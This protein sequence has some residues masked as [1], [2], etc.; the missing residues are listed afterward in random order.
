MGAYLENRFFRLPHDVSLSLMP[1]IWGGAAPRVMV[2][3]G[4]RQGEFGRTDTRISPSG[5]KIHYYY[6]PP[7]GESTQSAKGAIAAGSARGAIVFRDEMY[8][9]STA[10]GWLQDAPNYGVPFGAKYVS[11]FVELP[12]DYLVW[13]ENLPP[14]PALPRQ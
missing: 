7:V 2:G 4:D 8:D 3:L 13:P 10:E 14:V 5:V 11:I 6:D 1:A 9:L 12:P